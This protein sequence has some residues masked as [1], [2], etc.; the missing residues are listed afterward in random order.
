MLPGFMLRVTQGVTQMSR[1][2]LTDRSVLNVKHESDRREYPDHKLTGL[3]LIVHAAPSERKTW[4]VRTRIHGKP[5]KLTIP[6]AYPAVGLAAAR[7]IAGNLL[8]AVG[9][10]EDPR[11]AKP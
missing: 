11:H 10:G 5:V 4:A 9:R 1:L 3:Y 2:V 6:G 7:D 8:E